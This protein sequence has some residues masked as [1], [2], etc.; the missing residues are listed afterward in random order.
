VKLLLLCAAVLWP[1]LA[2]ASEGGHVDPVGQ[3]ALALVIILIAAK[4]GGD[5]AVRLGQPAVLGELIGGVLL[6]NLTL[7]GVSGLEWLKTD[8][9]VD[10][11]SRIGVPV[12]QLRLKPRSKGILPSKGTSRSAESAS[13]SPSNK[14]LSWPH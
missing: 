10:M 6:G 5:L 11:L 7:V 8:T 9:S 1:G 4:L 13:T 14:S 3:V 12:S 2:L